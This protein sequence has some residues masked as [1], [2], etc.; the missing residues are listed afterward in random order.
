MEEERIPSLEEL[1]FDEVTAILLHKWF[2]S[3]RVGYD[4]GMEFAKNDF[5]IYHSKQWRARKLKEDLEIQKDEIVKHKWFLS[6]RLGY[7]VG[8]TEAALDWITKGYAQQWRDRAGPY[9]DRR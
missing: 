1:S 7:D 9:K 8:F 4:V 3:E 2:L 6:E 5:F